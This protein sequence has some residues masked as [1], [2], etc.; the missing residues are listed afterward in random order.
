M[1]SNKQ[2]QGYLDEIDRYDDE[3]DSIR[4]RYMEECKGPRD[5]IKEIIVSAKDA[6]HNPVAFRELLK[7]HRADRAEEK[8]IAKMDLADRADYDTM[9]AAF[10]EFGDTPLG[11]AA[12]EK[13]K[14][15]EEA[16]NSLGRG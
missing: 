1:N 3:L 12:L 11:A 15:S 13:A 14:Q 6:G 4:G 9:L 8:R 16:L 7:T 5:A 10:G 2:L